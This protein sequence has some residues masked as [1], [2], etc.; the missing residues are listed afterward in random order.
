MS[1]RDYVLGTEAEEIARLG[2][3]HRVWRARML[4]GWARAGIGPGMN[5][6]DVGAGPGFAA[7]PKAL[8]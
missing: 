2:L 5:A 3:Q 7:T 1:D 4:D 8:S 6:I